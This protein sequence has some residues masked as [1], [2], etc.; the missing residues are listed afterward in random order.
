[1]TPQ[2]LLFLSTVLDPDQEYHVRTVSGDLH[3]G[4]VDL[5]NN[6][7]IVITIANLGPATAQLR[8]LGTH[9]VWIA[10]EAV[11]SIEERS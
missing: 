10:V 3:T 8:D 1:M 6:G 2:S 7:C 4:K 11:E 5:K 9:T